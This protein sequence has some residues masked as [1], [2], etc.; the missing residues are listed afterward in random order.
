MSGFTVESNLNLWALAGEGGRAIKKAINLLS[1]DHH[2]NWFAFYDRGEAPFNHIR[3]WVD[4]LV[5]KGNEAAVWC[6][7]SVQLPFRWRHKG[8][9]IRQR[10]AP[11]HFR[12]QS[13]L[14]HH[15]TKMTN[16]ARI[17]I[18]ERKCDFTSE[19]SPLSFQQST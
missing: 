19:A 13:F 6:F 16:I 4:R 9:R 3:S 5:K 11:S 14:G 17:G 8:G 2:E 10:D 15:L 7:Y 18:L 12:L 1:H